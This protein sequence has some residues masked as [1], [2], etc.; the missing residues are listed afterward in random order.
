MRF[1]LRWVFGIVAFVAIGCVCLTSASEVLSKVLASILFAFLLLFI[2][3]AIYGDGRLRAFCGGAAIAG[4]TFLMSAYLPPVRMPLPWWVSLSLLERAHEKVATE[5]VVAD[6]AASIASGVSFRN[7]LYYVPSP[8]RDPF[9]ACG[10]AIVASALA[11]IGGAVAQT[12]YE[13]AK[14]ERAKGDGCNY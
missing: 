1:S 7:G 5:T 12:V 9:M 11:L 6:P 8:Q 13:R 10:Q 3:V 14:G 4:W 2:F